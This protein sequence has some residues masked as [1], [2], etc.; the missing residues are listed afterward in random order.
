MGHRPFLVGVRFLLPE[1]TDIVIKDELLQVQKGFLMICDR[2][3]QICNNYNINE[4]IHE[5]IFINCIQLYKC[6][7]KILKIVTDILLIKLMDWVVGKA[8]LYTCKLS[9]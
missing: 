7:I 8:C 1:Q 2:I 9:P 6:V 3:W 4:I 5:Q